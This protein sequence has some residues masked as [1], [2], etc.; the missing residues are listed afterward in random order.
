M[1]ARSYY[2]LVDTETNKPVAV[3]IIPPEI[4]GFS[5]LNAF[6]AKIRRQQAVDDPISGLDLRS[7][8]TAPLDPLTMA[9]LP[10]G[11]VT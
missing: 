6:E 1:T 11:R 8:A 7:W 4:R 9:K 3:Y 2:Y 10:R 5:E